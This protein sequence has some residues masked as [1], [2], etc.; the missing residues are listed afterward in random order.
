MVKVVWEGCSTVS[1]VSQ[2]VLPSSNTIAFD[3]LNNIG[4]VLYM[5]GSQLGVNLLMCI[6]DNKAIY[7]TVKPQRIQTPLGQKKLMFPY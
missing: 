1:R 5:Q 6:H 4:V 2:W 3:G 7:Y